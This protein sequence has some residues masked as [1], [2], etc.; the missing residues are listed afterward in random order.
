VRARALAPVVLQRARRRAHPADH[1]TAEPSLHGI[2][3]VP[4]RGGVPEPESEWIAIS[5]YYFVGLSQRM[6]IHGEHTESVRIDFRPL[7]RHR[8]DAMPTGCMLLF[9]LR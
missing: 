3:Y 2:D 8:P 1:G 5:S 7:W 6:M 4:H 9:R